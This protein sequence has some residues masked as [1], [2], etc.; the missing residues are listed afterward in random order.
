MGV[1]PAL[2]ISKISSS[3]GRLW[4]PLPPARTDKALTCLPLCGCQSEQVATRKRIQ[5]GLIWCREPDTVL[6]TC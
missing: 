1:E 2:S 3:V 4:F 6:F 5:I